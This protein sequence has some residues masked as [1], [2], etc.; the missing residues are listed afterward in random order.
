ML[1]FPHTCICKNRFSNGDAHE[2]L[3]F[4]KLT[5]A[6]SN[7]LDIFSILTTKQEEYVKKDNIKADLAN[8]LRQQA[9]QSC[10]IQLY[11]TVAFP[12]PKKITCPPSPKSI[13]FTLGHPMTAEELAEPMRLTDEKKKQLT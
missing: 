11:D 13:A 2:D 1:S 5:V 3:S 6:I 9:P 8:L 12:A 7:L 10:F 4:F